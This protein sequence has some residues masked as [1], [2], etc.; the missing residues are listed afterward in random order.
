MLWGLSGVA[1]MAASIVGF[2]ATAAAFDERIAVVAAARDLPRGHVLS[3]ADLTPTE[4]LLGD[5]PHMLWTPNS[6]EA[7]AGLAV[8]HA[9]P[10]GSLVASHLLVE[11]SIGAFGDTLEVVVPLDTS[12]APSGVREGD[13]VLLIDPGEAP[14]LER[15]GRPRSVIRTLELVA[16]DGS[17]VRLF[18]PPAQWAWWR[19]LPA[20]LGATPMVLPMP[21]GGDPATLAA[22]L[23]GLWAA[24]YEQE[25]AAL[26]P[27]GAG[28]RDQAAPGELEVLTPM[29]LSLAPS[30][31]AEGDLVLLIDPGA[32][33]GGTGDGRPRSVLRAVRLEHYED[34]VLGIWA[35]PAEWVWWKSLPERLGAAPMVLR[36]PEGTDTDAMARDLDEQWR[37]AWEE[38]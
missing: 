15:A 7:L 36:V 33:H 14:S 31:V 9:L 30:G 24:S 38:R 8:E 37:N 2:W 3:E 13:A 22:E 28:W 21:L 19:A 20:R 27:F 23:D 26:Q 18:V 5:V 16:F 32:A 11:P 17:A 12:L 25:A 29:D 34:G 35:R 10:A 6:A 4:V 1:L